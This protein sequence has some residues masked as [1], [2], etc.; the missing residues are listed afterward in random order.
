MCGCA[1][2]CGVVWSICD[3][4]YARVRY[5][6]ARCMSVV[7]FC[8]CLSVFERVCRCAYGRVCLCYVRMRMISRS[9]STIY[10]LCARMYLILCVRLICGC[11]V[12]VC[13]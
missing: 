3:A 5:V 12:Y 8:L 6:D 7:R 2:V 9:L 4:L 11:F 10:L 1:Y 13:L